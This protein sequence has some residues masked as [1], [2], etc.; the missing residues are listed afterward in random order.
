VVAGQRKVFGDGENRKPLFRRAGDDDAAALAELVWLSGESPGAKGL[1]EV[2]FGGGRDFQL[3]QLRRLVRARTLSHFS[4]VTFFVAE[5]DGVV[6]AAACGFDPRVCGREKIVP[7][8]REIGWSGSQIGYAMERFAPVLTC[9]AEE[10]QNTWILEHVAT[11]PRFRRK[12]LARGVVTRVIEEGFATG[13]RQ[14]QVSLFLGNE[15]AREFYV[16]LGF[17][18][19]GQPRTDPQF[20]QVMGSPGTESLVLDLRDWIG[21]RS[22]TQSSGWANRPPSRIRSS[23]NRGM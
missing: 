2:F 12:G 23:R 4:H 8:L 7:A 21:S 15:V 1:Y 9:L 6:A 5:V 14:I 10:P 11:L 18:P 22:R 13:C 19:A 3:E 20:E 17:K 16:K